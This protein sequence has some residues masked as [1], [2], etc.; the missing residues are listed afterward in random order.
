LLPPPSLEG[1]PPRLARQV[2]GKSAHVLAIGKE[3]FYRQ[4]ELGV[5]AAYDYASEV[6]TRNMLARDAEEGIDAFIAKRPPAWQ[7]R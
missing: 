2:A 6:M 3:A 7:D 4:A 1:G 5:A